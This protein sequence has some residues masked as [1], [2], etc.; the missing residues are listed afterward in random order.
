MTLEQIEVD[1]FGFAYEKPI[2]KRPLFN[3]PKMEPLQVNSSYSFIEP[4]KHNTIMIGE[5]TT[6]MIDFEH[7]DLVHLEQ[8]WFLLPLALLLLVFSCGYCSLIQNY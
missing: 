8:V 7:Q 3:S 5:V 4:F 2:Q 1:L 6:S